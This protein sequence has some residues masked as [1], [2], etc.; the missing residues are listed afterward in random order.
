MTT[1]DRSLPSERGER[2]VLQ[3]SPHRE[4][5]GQTT[6]GSCFSRSLEPASEG[7]GP[8]HCQKGM[9]NSRDGAGAVAR[10][11]LQ[12]PEQI[13]GASSYVGS[14][15]EQTP[16]TAPTQHIPVR[17]PFA[18]ACPE[19]SP[20]SRPWN[21]GTHSD[22]VQFWAP[23]SSAGLPSSREMRSYWREPSAGLRG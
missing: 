18:E 17:G 10:C 2:R 1:D 14:V 11:S 19:P 23:L 16:R 22:C 12:L 9:T 13:P 4:P 21:K 7:T 5:R 6:A 3:K 8:V 15:S 20:A